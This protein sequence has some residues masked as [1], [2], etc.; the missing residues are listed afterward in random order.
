MRTVPAASA[1]SSERKTPRGISLS[2]DT[3]TIIA[4]AL[5][6][7]FATLLFTSVRQESQVFDESIHLYAGFQ[8]WKHGD[9]GTNPE[10]PPLAKML[11]ALPLLSLN[12]K[13]PAHF[14]APYFKMEDF[15]NSAKFLYGGNADAILM[16]GR[17]MVAL[18][19][20]ALAILV[21]LAAGE[22]FGPLAGLI[23]LGLLVFE[24]VVL[25]NGA[26]ITTD[27]PL[28]CLFF[29]SVYVFYRFLKRPSAPRL[30]L[31]AVA[32]GLTMIVKHSGVLILPTLLLLAVA[33]YILRRIPWGNVADEEK[34]ARR[35]SIAQLAG[36]L[37][38]IG[39]V[40]YAFI[41]TIYGFR[42]AARPDELVLA[43]TLAQYVTMLK[44]GQHAVIAFFARRHLFPEAYLYGWTDILLITSYRSTFIFGHLFPK[45]QWF[46]FPGIFVIK[47]TLGLMI[48]LALAPFAGI[49]GRRRE[50]LFLTIPA[51]FFLL[52]SISSM[53]NLG[54]RHILPI[55][56][57]C[58]VIAGAAGAALAMRSM[59]RTV[60]VGVLLALA[61]VSS[62]HSY[63]DF[64]A[65]S[66]EA[67]GG[68]SH[69]WRLV[70]DSNDDWGQGLK[71]TK[72]YVGRHPAQDCW[73]DYFNFLVNPAYY[74]ID[75][76][77]LPSTMA[78]LV[79]APVPPV[80]PT[81]S[82]TIYLSAMETSGL[83]SGPGQL[84]PYA[85]FANRKPDD[86]IGNVML[87]YRG[88]F[89][90][91]Q[92]AARS[93]AA[94]AFMLLRQQRV[95]EALALAQQAVLL[96]PN[97]AAANAALGSVLLAAGRT[98]EGQQAN[99]KAL[100]LAMADH[101]EFQG[102]LIG[103]LMQQSQGRRGSH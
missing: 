86:E 80:P 10:H 42:Y 25:S 63:P 41:W 26:L 74:G 77:P 94:N 103:S 84:N 39:M 91:S 21:Y 78:F 54:V 52:V 58:I 4:V 90:V 27:M 44:P 37:A 96:T 43:P 85:I 72:T 29:A 101:P 50:L 31:C 47:S 35:L 89:D 1:A 97:S 71:W 45:G 61:M 23:A 28:S 57:F 55:Y 81:I 40:G 19:S 79:G 76:K 68:P 33:D 14:P 30:A 2:Q 32:A 65:Y 83:T 36:A 100:R 16:R 34:T 6:V 95:P 60:A 9:F 8:Y 62:L 93:D 22:M 12:L 3:S 46:F 24:P 88:T 20:L 87:V 56:P 18:F 49:R 69:T 15:I 73:I 67:A 98:E 7:V 99:A 13:E 59:A 92:L 102:F 48:L 82:G 17:M 38:I 70:A 51:M 64:L 75:C 5:L 66:N 53:L 11:A